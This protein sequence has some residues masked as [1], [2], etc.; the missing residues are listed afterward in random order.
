[1]GTLSYTG[2]SGTFSGT[3]TGG[4]SNATATIVSDA[5]GT[6]TVANVKGIFRSGEAISDGTKTAT[7]GGTVSFPASLNVWKLGAST[8]G[9]SASPVNERGGAKVLSGFTTDKEGVTRTNTYN[10]SAG[11]PDV[12]LGSGIGWSMGAYEQD[13]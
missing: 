1:M 12:L 2:G 10:T 13:Q 3:L 11:T 7:A 6:V 8:A 9:G 5:A 4:S